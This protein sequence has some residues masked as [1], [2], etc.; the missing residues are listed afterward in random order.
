MFMSE[1]LKGRC[2]IVTGSST[3]I[4]QATAIRFARE[5]ARVILADVNRDGNAETLERIREA[6]GEACS[7][8]CDVSDEASVRAMAAAAEENFGPISIL[9]NNAG[10]EHDDGITEALSLE[11][12]EGIQAVNVRGPFL[13]AKHALP[14]MIKAGKGVIT[15]TSSVAGLIGSPGLHAYTA[16]KGAVISLTR[17]W[18]VTYAKQGIRA[19]AIC[20]GL[21]MTPM[22]Q[23]IGQAFIDG[24]IAAT[25]LGRGA[26][27]EE[28]ANLVTFL[29]SDEASFI[30]G[31]I[32]PIDGGLTAQ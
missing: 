17:S 24:G 28:I 13:V 5:G 22:V 9:F 14:S 16:S 30:T 8:N 18:A 6:G 23:R 31:S 1:L 3:G 4:G 25:P 2:A 19:N 11:K 10:T 29:S 15:T 20:P 21:V 12:W 32:I 7:V 26:K 27:P